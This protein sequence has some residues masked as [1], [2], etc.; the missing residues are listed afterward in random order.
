MKRNEVNCMI[1]CHGKSEMILAQFLKNTTRLPIKIV[2]NNKGNSSIQI[3][4]LCDFLG[5]RDLKT[6]KSLERNYDVVVRSDLIVFIVMDVDDCDK[7]FEN[8]FISKELFGKHFLKQYIKPI[9]NRENLEDVFQK[10]KLPATKSKTDVVKIFP[11]DK[12]DD[13][14]DAIKD[15]RDK[16]AKI[17]DTNM[18]ELFDF[19]L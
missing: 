7:D 16:L 11:V 5:R 6:A 17:P 8:R 1:I 14:K 12:F 9:Y 18:E 2:A 13:K 10:A 4:S 15:V 19:F 3:N